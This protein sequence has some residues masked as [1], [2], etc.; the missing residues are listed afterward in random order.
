MRDAQVADGW[1]RHRLQIRAE[2]GPFGLPGFSRRVGGEPFLLQLLLKFRR[3]LFQ[4]AGALG[5]LALLR[6][7]R[8]VFLDERRFAAQ[9]GAQ[10]AAEMEIGEEQKADCV[11]RK[12]DDGRA[13]FAEMAEDQFVQLLA[14]DPARAADVEVVGYA[15][16]EREFREVGVLLEPL[17]QRAVRVK[18]KHARA[19]EEEHGGPRPA[20]PVLEVSE[21]FQQVTQPEDEQQHRQPVRGRA[22]QEKEA[23][24][25]VRAEGPDQVVNRLVRRDAVGDVM[26]VKGKLRDE[27]Q[28]RHGDQGDADDVAETP[29]RRAGR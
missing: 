22:E 14:D 18:S 12:E 21:N 26:A 15:L 13:E 9:P 23:V 7:E 19:A 28:Q 29:R 4:I 8:F 25:D 1:R 6:R 27:Q 11:E 20:V 16:E 3:L 17:A 24:A 10:P 2:A 5:Q